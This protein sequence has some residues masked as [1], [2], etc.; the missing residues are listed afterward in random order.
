V[1][2]DDDAVGARRGRGEAERLDERAPAGAWLGSTRSGRWR[3]LL[4]HRTA[5][6]SSVKRYAG[7]ERADAALA[8]ASRR[9]ALLED[10]TPPP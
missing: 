1:H 2:L 3:E 5:V 7:L 9:V 10:V 8:Q 4:E 6:R